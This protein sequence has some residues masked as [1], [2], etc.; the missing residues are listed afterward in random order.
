M[1]GLRVTLG[2]LAR[3]IFHTGVNQSDATGALMTY[4]RIIDGV[5]FEVAIDDRPA[6]LLSPLAVLFLVVRRTTAHEHDGELCL[7]P[8]ANWTQGFLAGQQLLFEDDLQAITG[9]WCPTEGN[10][11]GKHDRPRDAGDA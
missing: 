3:G 1:A 4:N 8:A 11:T 10:G 9:D 5:R 6:G 2:N 7:R